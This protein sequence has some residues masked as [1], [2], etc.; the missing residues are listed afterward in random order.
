M[1]D[2]CVVKN[3]MLSEDKIFLLSELFKVFSD[4]TRIKII[5]ALLQRSLCVCDIASVT[6]TSVSAVS[7]QLRILKQTKLVKYKRKGK[8]IYYSLD[9]F[10]VKKIFDMG[11]EHINEI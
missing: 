9:D 1:S 7:H 6:D 2:L 5:C 10:H 8:T 11:C 4:A 3:K